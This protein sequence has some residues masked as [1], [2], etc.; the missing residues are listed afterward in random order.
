[1]K[2]LHNRVNIVP[3]IAKSDTLTK[4]EVNRLKKRV[5]DEIAK[6]KS[7]QLTVLY[8]HL[9]QYQNLPASRRRRRRGRRL[10]GTDSSLEGKNAFPT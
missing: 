9:A 1:M 7:Y 8:Q 2:S 3:V 4:Q 6:V 5:L 10:Q